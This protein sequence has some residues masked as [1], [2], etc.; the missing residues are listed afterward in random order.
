MEQWLTAWAL[1][2]IK[3]GLDSDTFM[4]SLCNIAKSAQEVIIIILCTLQ[5]SAQ[6]KSSLCQL[7]GY[8]L[9]SPNLSFYSRL[10]DAGARILQPAFLLCLRAP[11]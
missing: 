5:D 2:E 11:Y 10:F 8:Y 1:G 9:L 7:L 6:G 3:T 4:D